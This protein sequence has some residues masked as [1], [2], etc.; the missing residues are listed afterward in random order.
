M[1][2]RLFLITL[3]T[4]VMPVAW[5]V[6]GSG[7]E[8]LSPLKAVGNRLETPE[9]QAVRLNGVNIPSLEWGQG[10]HLFESL[11]VAVGNWRANVIRLPLSQDRWFG[12]MRERRDGGVSYRRTVHAFVDKAA[13]LKC[14]VILDLHWSDAGVWGQNIGQHKMPDEHSAEFWAWAAAEFAN[15]PAVLFGL[16]NEPYGV[17]WDIWRNGGNVSEDNKGAPGGKLQYHTPGMQKLLEVCRARRS[18]NV[19]VAGG[20]DW[21]YDLRGIA[22]GYALNDSK[23]NG[24]VY[25]THLYPMKQW[26]THGNTKSQ[27][28]DRLVMGAGA[29]F[30][31][32]IGEFGDGKDDY[33]RKV[34]EFGNKNNLPWVAW[35]LHP[36]ARPVL[37]EDWQYTPSAFGAVVKEALHAASR[38]P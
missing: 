32:M 12:H 7:E 5:M 22:D 15:Q 27:D 33:A 23:G 38:Q 3:L 37:I 10:D 13:S 9:G 11:K 21:A 19:I 8:S 18:R 30:P 24:V 17:S 2:V 1:A 25:D 36:A 29:K 34:L 26:Y 35:C 31:V 28:W 20:L 16:Y 6:K 14:Y 4:F